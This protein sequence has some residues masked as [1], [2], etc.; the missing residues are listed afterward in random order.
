MAS[1][2]E[3]PAAKHRKAKTRTPST[4]RG[5]ESAFDAMI[6]RRVAPPAQQPQPPKKH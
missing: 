2:Q 3:D 4:G 1:K 6:G 5:A